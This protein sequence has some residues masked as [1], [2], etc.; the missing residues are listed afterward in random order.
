MRGQAS[1]SIGISLTVVGEDVD[2]DAP[3]VE[4]LIPDADE[5][6]VPVSS[7]IQFNIKDY[8]DKAGV[9]PGLGVDTA[10]IEVTVQAG[11]DAPVTYVNGDPEFSISG[12]A[13]NR[14]VV[15]DPAD[16]FPEDTLIQVT[17]EA[18][19]LET[20]P[21]VMSPFVYSFRTLAPVVP[22][23]AD[24]VVVDDVEHGG[25]RK[26]V[27]HMIAD[28]DHDD[29]RTLV[30]QRRLPD[31]SV[32]RVSVPVE[33]VGTNPNCV[34]G[35]VHPSA[36]LPL[37]HYEDVEPGVW[38]EQDLKDLLDANILDAGQ[39]V[40]R[41]GDPAVRAE[42]GKIL[43]LLSGVTAPAVPDVPSFDDTDPAA[44]YY[45]FTEEAG[46]RGWM[47]GDDNCHGT[48]PCTLRPA[49]P[50]TRA[51]AVAMIVRYYGLTKQSLAPRFADVPAN[52]WYRDVMQTAADRCIMQGDALTGLAAPDRVVNRAEMITLFA[53]AEANLR[54]GTD[55]G[56]QAPSGATGPGSSI[57]ASLLGAETAPSAITGIAAL[58]VSAAAVGMA[59]V[60][61]FTRSSHVR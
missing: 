28:L 6:D 2:R 12:A 4:D 43:S 50:A 37:T 58:F 1:N 15:I 7:D 57:A 52:A 51:E 8:E 39:P 19:D 16:D 30:C 29:V 36:P 31:G 22:P 44:W 32:V 60:R 11:S 24:E 41:P 25:T 59:F 56:P 9:V 35:E 33:D 13:F 54:Y 40:F 5:T 20:P 53:R 34:F 55:C 18:S 14:T 48:H 26:S 47:R 46:R 42:F 45:A 27:P 23:A 10:S 17:I 3:Y 21:N 61:R 49:A 38:Y